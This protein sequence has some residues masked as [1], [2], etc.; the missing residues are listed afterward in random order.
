MSKF[1]P[2]R[3]SCERSGFGFWYISPVDGGRLPIAEVLDHGGHDAE[4]N[5]R[6]IAAAPALLE[7][8]Q[9]LTSDEWRHEAWQRPRMLNRARAAIAAATGEG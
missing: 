2:G 1:T 5:A 3:W 7:A 9:L 4:A 6:L 8:L